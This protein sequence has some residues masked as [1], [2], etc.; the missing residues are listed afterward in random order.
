MA[1]NDQARGIV[2]ISEGLRQSDAAVQLTTAAAEE[3]AASSESL[4]S[5]SK[6]LEGHLHK[7][8]TDDSTPLPAGNVDEFESYSTD[9]D[10]LTG[11]GVAMS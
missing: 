3:L 8:R 4:S 9:T 7:F 11:A 10:S 6:D 2:E 1:A 5:E